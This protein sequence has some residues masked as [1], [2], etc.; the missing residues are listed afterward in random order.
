[1]FV[2]T[3]DKMTPPQLP[4]QQSKSVSDSSL[5][6]RQDLVDPSSWIAPSATV[7]GEVYL[8][9]QA[10]I[11]FGTVIRG[12]TAPIT[13]QEQSNIQD[14]CCLHADPGFPCH[15]GKRVSIGH[16]AIVHGATIEDD[17]LIGIGSIV[18]NGAVI[19]T[20]SIVGA[21]ALVP[22]GKTIP[23]GSLVVGV[24]ARIIR[25]VTA[26]DVQRIK[27]AAEH[28]VQLSS[29][30]ATDTFFANHNSPQKKGS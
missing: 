14:L 7:V 3:K 28:Y 2:M 4:E 10:S 6:F 25:T 23:P 9:K 12:D 17:C 15:I 19:G 27:H 29:K 8:A 24:P 30:Y 20:G 1:M 26:E 11:W 13:I 5:G 16:G 18:L 21:G 22:E